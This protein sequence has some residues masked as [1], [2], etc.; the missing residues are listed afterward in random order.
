MCSIEADGAG[1]DT[2]V[3]RIVALVHDGF[4]ET[5]GFDRPRPEEPGA[6]TPRQQPI[7]S[8]LGGS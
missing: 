2:A 5:A 4:G 3:D 7:E 1:A 8:A 6:D